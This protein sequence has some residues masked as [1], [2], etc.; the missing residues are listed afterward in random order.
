MEYTLSR[1]IYFIAL[2]IAVGSALVCM[3]GIFSPNRLAGLEVLFV[4][5]YGFV[6]LIWLHSELTLPFYCLANIRY[7]TGYHHPFV[8]STP[9]DMPPHIHT[10]GLSPTA[11][12][13]NFNFMAILYLIPLIPLLVTKILLSHQTNSEEKLSAEDKVETACYVTLYCCLANLTYFL[14]CLLIYY[15]YGGS[16]SDAASQVI[17]ITCLLLTVGN[18]V[19]LG[20]YPA[21]FLEFRLPFKR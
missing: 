7:S 1:T 11:F 2:G 5:Q 13:S 17:A 12:Y 20:C 9:A 3:A 16:L 18:F 15:A 4:V 6:C 10:F 14:N 19:G 8:A 21:N